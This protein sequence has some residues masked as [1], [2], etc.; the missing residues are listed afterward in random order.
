[1]EK[2]LFKLALFI[3][4]I[5]VVACNKNESTQTKLH[6]DY[7]PLETGHYVVYDAMEI[8]H[9][10]QALI[11]RDTTRYFLK[12]VIGEP[13][14]DLE[15][16][17]AFKFFRYTKITIEADWALRDVWT[18][19]IK[20]RRAELVE[21]NQRRIK[22]V[23]APTSDK[24]W[25]INAFNADPEL[26]VRYND[27]SLHKN[28][29]SGSFNFDSTIRVDQRDFFSLV[30]HRKQYEIYA[31]GVGLVHK[32]YKDNSI[33]NFDT[34]NIRFGREIQYRILDYGKE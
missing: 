10:V 17:V 15:G 9:D 24:I 29:S 27:E 12:T 33:L 23:F 31:K 16:D 18:S 1:M 28:F 34:L 19:K 26:N 25:N 22:L 11:Q 13:I 14:I 3:C 2:G 30:D 7:Y 8:R 6:F 32:F 20:D 21:E 5:L 4:A